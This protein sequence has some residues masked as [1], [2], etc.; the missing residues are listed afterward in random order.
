MTDELK[1]LV[2]RWRREYQNSIY[3]PDPAGTLRHCTDEL[4][5]VLESP[6]ERLDRFIGGECSWTPDEDG[7]FQTGCNALWLLVD[8]T[9]TE[10]GMKFCA[11]CGKPIKEEA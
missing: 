1:R 4:E 10:N 6:A 3:D 2:E 5:T 11:F 7:D 9:P 8:G